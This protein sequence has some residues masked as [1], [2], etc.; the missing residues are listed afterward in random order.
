[1]KIINLIC[2]ISS[3][4]GLSVFADELSDLKYKGNRCN[5][6][7]TDNVL[8][9][10]VTIR[11]NALDTGC[12]TKE[13]SDK[14]EAKNLGARCDEN[15][16][17]YE[18]CACGCFSKGTKLEV[19]SLDSAKVINEN[20]ELV[21]K[22]PNEYLVVSSA[23]LSSDET[24]LSAIDLTTRGEESKDLFVIYTD[25]G[26][27]IKLTS[28]HPVI[29][30][31]QRIIQTKDLIVGDLLVGR[32]NNPLVVTKISKEKTKDLVYNL[33]LDAPKEETWSH[34]L[35][36]EGILVGDTLLQSQLEELSYRVK[37]RK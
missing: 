12:I 16:N 28:T 3:F 35:F 21:T 1:M 9:L 32:F 20:V 19:Y 13:E 4:V 27:K 33:L 26:N 8:S 15:F 30:Y 11:K 31:D 5:G 23:G 22:N 24:K 2:L 36:A 7:E 14:L 10:C 6:L 34:T 29:T 37:K 17:W 25:Q 18:S